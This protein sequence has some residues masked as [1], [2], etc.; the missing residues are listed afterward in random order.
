MQWANS[1][2]SLQNK[3][4]SALGDPF[5]TSRNV[6]YKKHNYRKHSLD[7]CAESNWV[8]VRELLEEL[9][10]KAKDT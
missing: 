8:T 7:E 6:Y 4:L 5:P 2:E 10:I 9:T 1:A 3:A